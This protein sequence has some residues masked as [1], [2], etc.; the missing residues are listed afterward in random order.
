TLGA[1]VVSGFLSSVLYGVILIQ[2]Y[3][4]ITRGFRDPLWIRIIVNTLYWVD[5]RI[6]ETTHTVVHWI[7]IYTLTVTGYG[8]PKAI[9]D[10]TL[11][12]SLPFPLTGIL[13]GMV[14]AFFAYRI[15]VFSK[16]IIIPTIA[17]CGASVKRG[18]SI[19]SCII[20]TGLA[21]IEVAA[22]HFLWVSL[23]PLS[24]GVAMDVLITLS[25]CFYLLRERAGFNSSK[26][27]ID[28]LVISTIGKLIHNLFMRCLTNTHTETGLITR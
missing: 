15:R 8:R 4:Y 24:I 20:L 26:T 28:K 9:L 10:K 25:L 22:A 19:A 12:M 14:Q 21:T 13:S 27:L 2:L 23:A 3:V 5:I 17:L 6:F 16:S 18:L 11:L 1:L 7:L